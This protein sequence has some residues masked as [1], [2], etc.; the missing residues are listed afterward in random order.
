MLTRPGGPGTVTYQNPMW[1]PRFAHC[2]SLCDKI[3]SSAL[4]KAEGS[5]LSQILSCPGD[6]PGCQG[7][8]A[9]DSWAG[10]CQA[11]QRAAALSLFFH[12]RESVTQALSRTPSQTVT[13]CQCLPRASRWGHQLGDD[14]PD[15]NR[16]ATRILR[17]SE[18]S[19]KAL[20]WAMIPIY[21]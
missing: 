14:E 18:R 12:D 13:A 17:S 10:D 7:P 21:L 15:A 11:G 20:T 19:C 5:M 16:A 3:F 8:E 1:Q 9:R 6:S 4:I 2:C